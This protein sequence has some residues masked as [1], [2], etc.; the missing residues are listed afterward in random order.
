MII[1]IDG[2]A[3]AGKSTTAKEV[4]RRTG[5]DYVDSGAMYRGFTYLYLEYD[6]D[7]T[8]LIEILD[9]HGL[10]FEFHITEARVFHGKKDI[11]SDIRSDSV[12]S[13]VSEVAAMEEVRNTVRQLLRDVS[14]DRDVVLEGRDLGT[15]VFPDA[16]LKFFLTAD[17]GARARRRYD[18]RILKG[19]QV[20]LEQ[21]RENVE[22]RDRIDSTRDI[23]P[24][25]KADD[26]VEID[27]T[28]LSFEEQ[29]T[30]ILKYIR[31][32]STA[33]QGSIS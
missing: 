5:F 33:A 6:Q 23:A 15:V 7:R 21:V 4:A 20:S 27:S 29:V 25:K 26:A 8:R 18:E 24:L 28:F 14:K 31:N 16:D 32:R 19:E 30:R 10:R 13:R 3:G 17:P 22:T 2:P 12:N 1:V 11:T 9:N